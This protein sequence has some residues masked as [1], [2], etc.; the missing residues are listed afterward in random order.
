MQPPTLLLVEDDPAQRLLLGAYLRQGGHVVVEAGT[1][2]EARTKVA[3]AAPALVLLDL[4]L[5]DG[6]GLV[7]ARELRAREVPLVIVTSREGDRLLALELGADDYLVKP[8]DP[9][10][11]AARVANVL[12]RCLRAPEGLRV[13][14]YVLDGERRTLQDAQ[15]KPIELT[16]GEFALLL[17]LA[18]ARGCVVGRAQLSEAVSPD[19]DASNLRSVDVLVSRLRQ[20]LEPDPA[21]PRLILTAQGLGYRLAR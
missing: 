20:K 2:A 10:E 18:E 5:P 8:Y 3:E 21:N 9:R 12:R 7:L 14:S 11:L 16:P 6:D 15:G 13:G 17:E 4:G 1:L 19:R